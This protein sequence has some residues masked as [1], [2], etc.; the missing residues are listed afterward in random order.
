MGCYKSKDI[1]NSVITNNRI[2]FKSYKQ[3]SSADIKRN[4]ITKIGKNSW[5]NIIDFLSYKELHQVGK[6]NR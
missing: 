4:Y 5:F 1:S 6:I 3:E 2:A